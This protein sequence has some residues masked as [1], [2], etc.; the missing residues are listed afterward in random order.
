MSTKTELKALSDSTFTT[1][2]IRAI[3]AV[4]HRAFN[5]DLIDSLDVVNFDGV[6]K[7]V[8]IRYEKILYVT[9]Y[10]MNATSL[11][12][13]DVK[14]Q[15]LSNVLDVEIKHICSSSSIEPVESAFNPRLFNYTKATKVVGSDVY[16]ALDSN[17]ISPIPKEY[18]YYGTSG[19]VCVKITYIPAT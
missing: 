16:L 13:T 10:T 5:D 2:G 17:G 18:N 6:E 15:L 12:M 1:N 19:W 9:Y 4:D 14:D 11:I 7:Q 3:E 8:A